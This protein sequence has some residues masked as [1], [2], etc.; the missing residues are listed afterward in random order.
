[1][2]SYDAQY[3]HP[4]RHHWSHSGLSRDYGTANSFLTTPICTTSRR[5]GRGRHAANLNCGDCFAY[6]LAKDTSA[7]L[8]RRRIRPGRCNGGVVLMAFANDT[9]MRL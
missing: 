8:Q 3:H 1:M 7:P 6:A 9:L 2:E 5:Y 4:I